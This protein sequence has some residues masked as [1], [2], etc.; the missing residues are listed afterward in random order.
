MKRGLSSHSGASTG[1]RE[2]QRRAAAGARPPPSRVAWRPRM[3]TPRPSPRAPGQ[4]V[5]PADG[6]GPVVRAPL[7]P[8]QHGLEAR[9]PLGLQ[10]DPRRLHPAEPQRHLH[11]EAG[12]PHAAHGGE[13]E[14]PLEVG[15]ARDPLAVGGEQ[16]EP[17][18]EAGRR[19]RRGGGSCRGRRRPRSRPRS[20]TWCPASP[21]GTSRAAG[22]AAGSRRGSAPP[23]SE[24]PGVAVEAQD[25]V[26][27]RAS[28][29]RASPGAAGIAASP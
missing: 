21:A 17:L 16:D 15:P 20:R 26:G 10:H 13:E 8:G 18:H 27:P 6:V 3:S 29:P 5:D 22:T 12:E 25:A 7:E 4:A 9:H 11:D 1:T 14:L 24:P 2:R 28:P 19:S 23:R